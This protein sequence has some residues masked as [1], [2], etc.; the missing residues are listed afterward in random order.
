MAEGAP[1]RAI[2][3][4]PEDV[5]IDPKMIPQAETRPQRPGAGKGI[6]QE[7]DGPSDIADARSAAMIAIMVVVS[8]GIRR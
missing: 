7:G 2:R 5:N 4:I 8:S 3:T 6:T 1:R